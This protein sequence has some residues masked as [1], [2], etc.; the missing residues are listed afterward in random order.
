MK[1]QLQKFAETRPEGACWTQCHAPY[2][3]M[4]FGTRGEVIACCYNRSNPLGHYPE[5]SLR[6]IWD[7]KTARKLRTDMLSDSSLPMGCDLCASQV[8][9]GNFSGLH[10]AKYDLYAGEQ[11]AGLRDKT[12]GIV[13]SGG[14]LQKTYPS[15]MEFELSNSCNL[16]CVMCHGGFSSSIRKNREGLDPLP[17][18]Y[19]EKFVSQLDEFIPHLTDSKFLGGEPFLIGIYYD[20]WDRMIELNPSILTHITTNGSILNPRVKRVVEKLNVFMI[21][22]ID[23]MVRETYDKIRINSNFDQV[24][25]S[26]EYYYATTRAKGSSIGFATCPMTSNW[27]EMP[28][29]VEY[30]NQKEISIYFN[31]VIFPRECSLQSYSS[32]ELDKVIAHFESNSPAEGSLNWQ[33][34]SDLINQCR[35]W[36]NEARSREDNPQDDALGW[37]LYPNSAIQARPRIK[38]LQKLF[39]ERW[40]DR[41]DLEKDLRTFRADC[42][43]D[44]V[45]VRAFL[46]GAAYAYADRESVDPDTSVILRKKAEFLIANYENFSDRDAYAD[47]LLTTD[48]RETMRLVHGTAI[49]R[50]KLSPANIFAAVS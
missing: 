50:L 41:S 25:E 23:S 46:Y 17:N 3:S 47:R 28:D 16:E 45:F 42:P 37:T 30:C 43:D 24:Q 15:I 5:K 9:A 29:L 35:H 18:P 38:E 6:E 31:T 4:Y 21:M 10:A 22:S 34:L 12:G 11:Q 49:D 40:E 2:E 8:Q 1:D 44:F 39:S 26:I 36:R 20:I 33:P 27:H 13:T 19:D 7:G 14:E 48:P 32:A